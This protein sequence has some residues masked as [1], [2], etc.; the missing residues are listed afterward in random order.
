MNKLPFVHYQYVLNDDNCLEKT[1]FLKTFYLYRK[2][3]YMK[4]SFHKKNLPTELALEPP[5]EPPDPP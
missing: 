3:N 4:F 1:E 2:I 5:P